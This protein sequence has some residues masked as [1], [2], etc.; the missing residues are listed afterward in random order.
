MQK[1]A[2]LIAVLLL[3]TVYL[4]LQAQTIEKQTLYA[5]KPNEKLLYTRESNLHLSNNGTNSLFFIERYS[6]TDTVQLA[7]ANGKEFGPYSLIYEPETYQFEQSGHFWFVAE[8][9]GKLLVN[10]N[11]AE[12]SGFDEINPQGNCCYHLI[13]KDN[14][15]YAFAGKKGDQWYV[16][17][18]GKENKVDQPGPYRF[19]YFEIHL[20]QNNYVYTSIKND[21]T[22]ININGNIIKGVDQ[23]TEIAYD[24]AT[25]PFIEYKK[26]E[27]TFVYTLEK[28][29]GPFDRLGYR[30]FNNNG[31]FCYTYNKDNAWYAQT[32]TKNF[33]P[34]EDVANY[35]GVKI[36]DQNNYW[37]S[38]MKNQLWYVI[39]NDKEYGPYDDYDSYVFFKDNRMY[40]RYKKQENYYYSINGKEYGPYDKP[41]WT[42]NSDF[43]FSG[44]NTWYITYTKQN[45]YGLLINGKETPAYAAIE[46]SHVFPDGNYLIIYTADT[47]TFINNNGIITGPFD[48]SESRPQVN[49]SNNGNYITVMQK[50]GKPVIVQNNKLQNS[51]IKGIAKFIDDAGNYVIEQQDETFLTNK[52]LINK[53][54]YFDNVI[55]DKSGNMYITL[56][57][58]YVN[59]TF[60]NNIEY[61]YSQVVT[62]KNYNLVALKS[63]T[64]LYINLKKS[65][66]NC[67]MLQYNP[68][69]DKIQWLSL[70]NNSIVLKSVR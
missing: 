3:T 44:T 14:G 21:K 35:Y 56:T 37:F 69:T 51:D 33:G 30:A 60:V 53:N 41:G 20:Y 58:Y 7:I 40:M 39:A 64:D 38:Y 18:N 67:F 23:I 24:E 46:F 19:N 36:D 49:T 2:T 22:E 63:G 55:T 8:K 45:T 32:N 28:Q 15:N 11:G 16:Y 57:D 9:D 4:N 48:K 54:L 34:F 10:V 31:K 47:K 5:L 26:N 25:A 1:K 65:D 52:G 42:V 50:D 59:T 66:E 29:F 27:A 12:F 6:N 70:E 68:A 62:N 43:L 61:K 17:I 13:I